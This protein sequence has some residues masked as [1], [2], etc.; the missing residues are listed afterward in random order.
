MESLGIA[1]FPLPPFT[2]L[3]VV[4]SPIFSASVSRPIKS[5]TRSVSGLF[6]SQNGSFGKQVDRWMDRES[7]S[8]RARESARA[9]ERGRGRYRHGENESATAQTCELFELGAQG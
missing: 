4:S 7:E 9:T 5:A 3:P 1:L 8:Q 6:L 2:P